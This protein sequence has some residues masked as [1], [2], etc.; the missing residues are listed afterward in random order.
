MSVKDKLEQIKKDIAIP[1]K[2]SD[3]E[4]EQIKRAFQ[5]IR[6]MLEDSEKTVIDMNRDEAYRYINLIIGG[7]QGA[8][9]NFIG[10]VKTKEI[11]VDPKQKTGPSPR[12]DYEKLLEQL[13][14]EERKKAEY[15]ECLTNF[16]ETGID[17]VCPECTLEKMKTCIKSSDPS[18]II[19]GA[20]DGPIHVES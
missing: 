2:L 19:K 1:V 15:L 10:G 9:V 12:P 17:A 5:A 3:N 14:P 6:E 18:I 13:E 8:D 20:E 11:L 4:K 16:K 7:L